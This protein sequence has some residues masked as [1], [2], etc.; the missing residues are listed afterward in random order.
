MSN[1]PNRIG[2]P[3]ILAG[4]CTAESPAMLQETAHFLRELSRE[5]DFDFYFKASFD[6]AN[7]SSATTTRGHGMDQVMTWFADLKSSLKVKIITDVHETYQVEPDSQVV[8]M[9]QIPAFLCR[10]T[11]LV[12][13]AA[14]TACDMNIKKGQFMAPGAMES[15]IEKARQAKK[16]TSDSPQLGTIYVTERGASFGYGDLVV[17]MR[18]FAQ[19]A[20][21]GAPV[22]FDLTHSVQK[23]PLGNT[24]GPVV[25]KANR[26]YI[27]LL[28]R[29]A[30]A[31]GKLAGFFLEVHP[32]PRLALSDKDSQLDFKQAK[33]LLQQVL[34]LLRVSAEWAEIDRQFLDT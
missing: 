14:R 23:P 24:G 19:M 9:L 6:K 33:A 5:L 32:D 8:D 11:D 27:P 1:L 16:S 29:A 20:A 34:P 28:G 7:R 31:T 25:S 13:A 2:K 21:S 30:A 22:L 10:Q 26:Q 3:L 18:G 12:V 4:P 15:I 17:D